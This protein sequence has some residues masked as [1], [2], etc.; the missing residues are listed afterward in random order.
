MNCGPSRLAT[1]AAM[2]PCRARGPPLSQ[3]H[4]GKRDTHCT[5][6]GRGG[7]RRTSPAQ[8]RSG[9]K[10]CL[11]RRAGPAAP[12]LWTR[13]TPGRPLP[14][15]HFQI[16]RSG[17]AAA[18]RRP[19]LA[20]RSARGALPSF[21]PPP[22][23]PA[24]YLSST[25][26]R[27]SAGPSPGSDLHASHP[28]KGHPSPPASRPRGLAGGRGRK[29]KRETEA[30]G[31]NLPPR[32]S[33]TPPRRKLLSGILARRPPGK[34]IWF[35]APAPLRRGARRYPIGW[36]RRRGGTG[37]GAFVRA[38]AAAAGPCRT[39]RDSR[40]PPWWWD[41]DGT[42]TG[43]G[44]GTPRRGL[45]SGTGTVAAVVPVPPG[46]A[47]RAVTGRRGFGGGGGAAGATRGNVPEEPRPV[48]A[49]EEW[50]KG[51]AELPAPVAARRRSSPPRRRRLSRSLPSPAGVTEGGGGGGAGATHEVF[52]APG[53]NAAGELD[54]VVS[55]EGVLGWAGGLWPS[56][57]WE[58]RRC[59]SG[60]VGESRRRVWGGRDPRGS[61]SATPPAASR[62]TFPSVRAK[63]LSWAVTVAV[64]PVAF[65]L[66]SR[67]AL[68]WCLYRA[69]GMREVCQ[70]PVFVRQQGTC[71][72]ITRACW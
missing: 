41:G 46:S 36:R 59:P 5:G 14:R 2:A 45:L 1:T 54:S 11:P 69:W 34:R 25:A 7:G 22:P 16:H 48:G 55:V 12:A 17:G 51:V 42:G 8:P 4:W 47:L 70:M 29:V 3:R 39:Y 19:V 37:R 72:G 71:L 40:S 28:A 24:R 44:T 49:W 57:L 67:I 60:P 27:C 33:L 9:P 38:A 31:P 61:R 64:K 13:S 21:S 53:W 63:K 15:G 65:Y 43:T 58:G 10:R 32:R 68:G 66:G 6:R 23:P 26:T 30:A 56:A 52:S 18:A 35:P 20:P 62:D 50:V